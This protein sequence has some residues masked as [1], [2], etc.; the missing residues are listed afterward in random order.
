MPNCK[1]LL[2]NNENKTIIGRHRAKKKTKKAPTHHGSNIVHRHQLSKI[3]S[4]HRE[5]QPT[6]T[7]KKY[8]QI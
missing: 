1:Y 6:T 7:L 4:E 5:K 3:R 2:G 8:M